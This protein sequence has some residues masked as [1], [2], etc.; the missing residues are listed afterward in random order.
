MSNESRLP[1]GLEG[2]YNYRRIDDRLTTSGVVGA[3]RLGRL[4]K[5]GVGVVIDLLPPGTPH[6][7]AG[8]AELVRAQG[9]DYVSIPVDWET[10]SEA[11]YR[12]FC[13]AMD[14][15]GERR[16]HVHCAANWRVSAFWSL[17]ALER[18]TCSA[19]QARALVSG[20]WNPDEYPQWRALIDALG[21]G[22]R[23]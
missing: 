5:A 9:V 13:E 3:D 20:L 12:A 16:V 15:A 10:P 4:V 18:G 14:A 2:S 6:A 11:D 19:E 23:I 7:V 17:Y 22:G 1:E 8:E 21:G